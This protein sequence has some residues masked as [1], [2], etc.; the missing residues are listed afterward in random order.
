MK[1]CSKCHIEQPLDSFR[2]SPRGAQGR[3]SICRTCDRKYWEENKEA[4]RERVKDWARRNADKAKQ[5]QKDYYEENKERIAE[6]RK[7]KRATGKPAEYAKQYRERNKTQ[8]LLNERQYREQRYQDPVYKFSMGVRAL[9][10]GA[11]KR[12]GWTK[13]TKTF[14]ILGCSFEELYAHLVSTALR[15]YGYY[16]EGQVM[17]IDHVVPI[18]TAKTEEDVIRLNHYTNLQW[19]TPEDNLKKGAKVG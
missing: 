3:R 4:H 6:Q 11:F 16:V 8:L 7:Q 5:I 1:T 15:N 14:E 10:G 2:A 19:L 17:H 12:G 18:A 13:K 9:L